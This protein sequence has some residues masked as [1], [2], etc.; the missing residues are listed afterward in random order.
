MK[1][2]QKVVREAGI[3]GTPSMLVNDRYR[4]SAGGAV[5][6]FDTMLAIVDALVADEQARMAAAAAV[7]EAIAE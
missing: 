4:V 5:N 1:N 2:E 7:P 3:S 6:S